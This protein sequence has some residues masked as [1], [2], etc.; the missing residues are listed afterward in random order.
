MV[1]DT[2]ANVARAAHD[3]GLAA[4]LGGSMY[5]KFA[6]NPAVK[7]IPD[8]PVRG[9]VT[10]AA[11]NGYNLINGVGLGA[12]AVGWSAARFTE[13]HPDKL[14]PR[15]QAVSVT[16]DVLM[17]T[18][19]LTGLLNGVQAARLA[20]QAPGGAV[21]IESGTVPAP[22][23]PP[24]AAKIQRSLGVLGNLNILSGVALIATNG[25]LAQID[26]S[27]PPLKRAIAR[28]NSPKGRGGSRRSLVDLAGI[29]LGVAAA[30]DQVRRLKS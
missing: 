29:T 30:T 22:E 8:K 13:A 5:G 9:S 2:L 21:P 18:A 26:H 23:T 3:V 19:V 6:L 15:E 7:L 4:W 11:W 24:A 12:A 16:K 20:K 10:N 25:V 14:S 17:G 28:R 27:R 1:S